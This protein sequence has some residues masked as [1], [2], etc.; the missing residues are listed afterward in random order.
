MRKFA[1]IKFLPVIPQPN[2]ILCAGVNYRAHA[3][4]VWRRLQKQPSMFIRFTD[5]LVGHGG[6]NDPAE[7]VRQVRL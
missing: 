4:E 3:A 1:D 2:K 7:T 6:G 5:T